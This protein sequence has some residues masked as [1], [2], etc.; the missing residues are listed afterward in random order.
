MSEEKD[1]TKGNL[2]LNKEEVD[3]MPTAV[4]II[5]DERI[6]AQKM[7]AYVEKLEEQAK[8]SKEDA[9]KEAKEALIATGVINENG[10]SK[11][12]IVSWE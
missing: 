8:C 11:T 12:K 9:K 4:K 6:Y 7:K 2:K 1:N 5:N 3:I 10:S